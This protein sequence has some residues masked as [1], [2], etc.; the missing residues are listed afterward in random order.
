[1]TLL[2]F[3]GKNEN[4]DLTNY[5]IE[6]CNTYLTNFFNNYYEKIT[7]IRLFTKKIASNKLNISKII[8]LDNNRLKY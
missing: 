4:F 5:F 1:M 7:Q 3:A 2:A 6:Y 8:N